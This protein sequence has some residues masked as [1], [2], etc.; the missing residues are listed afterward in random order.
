MS[1]LHERL[2][3]FTRELARSRSWVS[4]LAAGYDPEHQETVSLAVQALAADLDAALTAIEFHQEV[5]RKCLLTPELGA[6][7]HARPGAEP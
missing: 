6:L 1:D 3:R 2:G 7:L 4:A 5:M